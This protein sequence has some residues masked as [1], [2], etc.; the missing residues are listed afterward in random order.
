[1]NQSEKQAEENDTIRDYTLMNK[2]D[3]VY[4]TFNTEELKSAHLI[5]AIIAEHLNEKHF[6]QQIEINRKALVKTFE[7]LDEIGMELLYHAHGV[8][9]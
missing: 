6:G 7:E 5:I 9:N 1:M 4:K 2:I 3:K 8:K